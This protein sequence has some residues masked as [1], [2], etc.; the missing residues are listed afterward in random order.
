MLPSVLS[1]HK[2]RVHKVYN[3][4]PEERVRANSTIRFDRNVHADVAEPILFFGPYLHLEP[5]DYSFRF[6]G[7]LEGSLGLRFTKRFGA[8]CLKE[9][10]VASFDAPVRVTVE[11]AAEKVEIVGVRLDDT[12]A[13]TLSSIEL[14]REAPAPAQK[15]S[16]S[17]EAKPGA[18]P[19]NW[20]AALVRHGA[21]QLVDLGHQQNGRG[22]PDLRSLFAIIYGQPISDDQFGYLNAIRVMDAK[23]AHSAMRRIIGA[24]DRQQWGTPLNIRFD[25]SDIALVDLD[26]FKLAIDLADV[27]V[28]RH[29]MRHRTYEPHVT[30]FMRRQIKPGMNVIDVG[31]NIGYFTVLASKLVG[32]AGTVVAFEANSENAR[33]I[34]LDVEINNLKNVRLLPTALSS[35]MGS[36]YFSTH[37]GSNGGFLSSNLEILQNSRCVVVPTFRLDQLIEKQV[38]LMKLDVE[39]AEG[40]VVEGGWSTISKSRPIVVSEF[41]P[42]MLARVSRTRALDYLKRFADAG[43][44]VFLLERDKADGA[45][46]EIQDIDAFL[47]G[48]GE[49][50][51]IE[52]LAFVPKAS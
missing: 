51:R 6:N 42:E 33:L 20:A 25:A 52:D 37:L 23:N 15:P 41:S 12:L 32:D 11:T 7:A 39:G 50:T 26:G 48:Y 19:L 17:A 4:A 44:R 47:E 28:G 8:E 3:A 22:K 10:V 18:T 40:L 36:A 24:I 29:I 30:A 34:L 2:M 46:S 35:E 5:G 9:V 16:L 38:D 31:A 49:Q 21:R 14:D 43:Y 13:M 1:A 27:S 45:G